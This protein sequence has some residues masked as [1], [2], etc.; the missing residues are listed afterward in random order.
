MQWLI[1]LIIK[2]L[3][4]YT[5]NKVWRLYDI[6]KDLTLRILFIQLKNL[7][8]FKMTFIQEFTVVCKTD[9]HRR[10]SKLT[11]ALLLFLIVLILVQNEH[12]CRRIFV[13]RYTS[14]SKRNSWMN[15]VDNLKTSQSDSIRHS[16][17]FIQTR[18]I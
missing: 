8:L 5:Y 6:L 15:S 4:L 9:S 18:G 10:L 7:G 16:D 1:M 3:I 17:T 13:K 2:F 14:V 11:F 12:I